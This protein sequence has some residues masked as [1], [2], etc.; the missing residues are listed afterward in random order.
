LFGLISV[1]L[2]VA[3]LRET[4]HSKMAA[5]AGLAGGVILAGFSGRFLLRRWRTAPTV[6]D[7]NEDV[8]VQF[9]L[10]VFMLVLLAPLVAALSSRWAMLV[11]LLLSAAAIPA[12]KFVR[13]LRRSH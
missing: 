3:C 11:P 5:E 1:F 12:R 7:F 9:A 10:A 4:G 8:D 6:A 2:L 13:S